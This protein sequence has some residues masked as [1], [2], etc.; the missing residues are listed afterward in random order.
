MSSSR[1]L[2]ALLL[3]SLSCDLDRS[4]YEAP[5]Y[6]EGPI[7]AAGGL[8][9][10]DAPRSRLVSLRPGD[11]PRCVRTPLHP[12]GLAPGDDGL[13][14]MG[15]GDRG[16]ELA[17]LVGG[18]RDRTIL[19]PSLYDEIHVTPSRDR[20]ILL[21]DPEKAPLPGEP[22]A[23]NLA[24]FAVVSLGEGRVE[25]LPLA[26]GGLARS[27]VF[28][29][30]GGVAALLQDRA[31]LVFDPSRPDHRKLAFLELPSGVSLRPQDA[32]FSRD[33]AYLAVRA[34]GTDD[35][36]VLSIH[37]GEGGL[38]LSLNLLTPPGGGQ[39]ED[40]RLP[41]GDEL[42]GTL[43]V[44]SKD[45]VSLLDFG[46]DTSS[47][48]SARLAGRPRHVVPLEGGRFLLAGAAEGGGSFVAGWDPLGD[49]VDQ[50]R[51]DGSLLDLSHG[52]E[53][54]FLLH[55]ESYQAAL[56][57]VEWGESGTGPRLRLQ[58]FPIDG[59]PSAMD[60]TPDGGR[61][62]VGVEG[63]GGTAEGAALI[64]LHTDGLDIHGMDLDAPAIRLGTVGAH[65]WA[66]HP[67][68]LG[69]VTFIPRDD[70]SRKRARRHEGLL[71]AGLLECDP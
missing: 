20:A 27:V 55:V 52:G 18:K 34:L 59:S 63:T 69:D 50:S 70:L 9:W 40:L 22:A 12:R 8:H 16:P 45:R 36:L 2:L 46:G 31:V 68:P 47:T 33:G 19:L 26:T 24:R 25:T 67:S 4:A 48:R 38:D 57:V 30:D 42:D 60:E 5:L 17:R 54:L 21:Y 11:A 43:A 58:T 7:V 13:W 66:L 62:L 35:L 71:H 23:R 29:P 39:I 37:R 64:S 3:F 14:L 51:I 65:V 56:T 6:P 15:K 41:L 44:V 28:S 1:L 61:I 49:G 10:L 32:L 53:R